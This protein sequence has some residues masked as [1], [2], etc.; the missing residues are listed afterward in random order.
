MV[1][2]RLQEGQA[3]AIPLDKVAKASLEF[4]M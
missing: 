1:R 3:A 4:E 2:I